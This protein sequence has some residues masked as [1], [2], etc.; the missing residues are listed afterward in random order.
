MVQ[1]EYEP[2]LRHDGRYILSSAKSSLPNTAGSQFFITLEAAS[3][4]DDKHSIFG[5]VTGGQN[6]IDSFTDPVQ[7]PTDAN[8]RPMTPI[9]M[10]SVTI[11]GPD[12]ITFDIDNPALGLPHVK[13]VTPVIDF[14]YATNS[15]L[16]KYP[17]LAQ[18]NYISYTS[19][20][21]QTWNKYAHSLSIN[22]D[23][24]HVLTIPNVTVPKFFFSHAAIDYSHI[25]NPPADLLASGSRF[26]FS[27]ASGDTVTL[28]SDGAGAGTWTDSD[29]GSGALTAF[30]LTDSAPATGNFI[31]GGEQAQFIPLTTLNV[32]F[33]DA[34]GAGDWV[35]LSGRLSFHSSTNGGLEGGANGNTAV[36]QPFT[37]TP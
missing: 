10:D 34:A 5:K 23:A 33:S 14:D 37:F 20:D 21:L 32:E 12:Y 2:T 26:T 18:H 11:S 17:R 9:T 35:T 28:V 24:A 22:D 29:G 15:V 3:A 4:L 7:F 30:T 13:G 16:I 36:N 31:S 25:Y 1:D 8:E 27:N 6:I 19:L